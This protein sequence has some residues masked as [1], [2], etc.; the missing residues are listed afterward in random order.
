MGEIEREGEREKKK[1]L[2]EGLCVCLCLSSS[3]SDST[4]LASCWPRRERILTAKYPAE[5]SRRQSE[6][7]PTCSIRDSQL[8]IALVDILEKLSSHFRTFVHFTHYGA[9]EGN[10]D[11]LIYEIIILII[12]MTRF[13]F[14]CYFKRDR[15][16]NFLR[17][18]QLLRKH[19]LPSWQNVL[20]E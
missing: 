20:L 7:T 8:S 16:V 19:T 2:Y 11:N 13:F 12:I 4:P 9:D 17:V 14:Y 6:S 10:T 15:F 18:F 3:F 5:W 1:I